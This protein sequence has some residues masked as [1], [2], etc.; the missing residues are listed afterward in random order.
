MERVGLN[1]QIQLL[2]KIYAPKEYALFCTMADN[3]G[4]SKTAL[5]I[6]LDQMGLISRNDFRNPYALVDVYPDDEEVA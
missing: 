5:S 6:R 3:L 4:V 2:N 1:G